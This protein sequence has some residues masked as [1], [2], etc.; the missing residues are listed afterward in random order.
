M[1]EL[2]STMWPPGPSHCEARMADMSVLAI[3]WNSLLVPKLPLLD[4]IVRTVLV[5]VILQ[6]GLRLL[7]NKE[8]QHSASHNVVTLFLVGAFGGRSVLG[9][10]TS[11]TSCVLGLTV[12]LSLNAL[13]S[14]GTF[15]SRRFLA[16]VEGPVYQ[17]VRD[18]S[19]CE[20]NMRRARCS[21]DTLR[22]Q[23]RSRGE[24]DFSEV[25][26]AFIERTGQITFIM[27]E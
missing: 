23:L 10:D 2:A 22:A 26:H 8:L 16:F 21:E 17:V 15:H 12:V 20:Q 7:G 27:R 19:L 18:G 4:V 9:E 3:N 1:T 14:Y 13:V 6:V 25:K 11:L 24:N 5:Y